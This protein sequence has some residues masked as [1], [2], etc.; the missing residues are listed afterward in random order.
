ME[1][2]NHFKNI[3]NLTIWNTQHWSNNL[4]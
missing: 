1:K 2:K 4:W 3:T